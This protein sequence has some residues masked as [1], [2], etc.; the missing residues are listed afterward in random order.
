MAKLQ[1]EDYLPTLEETSPD[2]DGRPF[3][4]RLEQIDEDP[5]QPRHEFDHDTLLELAA[6]IRERGVLQPVS[7]RPNPQESGRWVLNF[8][9]RRVRASKLAGLEEIPVLVD[10]T[11]DTYDQ[12]IENEQREGLT[13]LELAGFVQ[14]RLAAGDKKA[15]IARRLGK[16]RQYLTLATALIEAPDWLLD[17]YRQGRCRGMAELY[18]LRHLHAEHPQ[19]VEAWVGAT[20]SITRERLASLRSELQAR[21]EPALAVR[22]SVREAA[23][24]PHDARPAAPFVG[25]SA[26]LTRRHS[27]HTRI[28][29]EFEGQDFELDVNAAPPTGESFYIRPL[30]GGPRTEVRASSLTLR[31]FV[32][33]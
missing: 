33:R 30:S 32:D 31:G 22:P 2:P 1:L 12:L 26:T 10:T 18:E 8:G 15:E 24:G 3:L 20:P 27:V 11:G 7:V 6:T 9:A 23:P 29:V 14:K 17:T 16:S 4:L 5:A 19:R 25:S 13:P 28:H 21:R